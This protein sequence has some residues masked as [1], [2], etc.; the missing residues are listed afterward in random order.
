MRIVYRLS[1]FVALLGAALLTTG[2][3]P[4][5]PPGTPPGGVLR[6]PAIYKLQD[7]LLD[8]PVAPA[9]SAYTAVDGKRLHGYVEDLTAISRRYRD[10][11]HPQ[12]WGRIIGTQA[13]HDTADWM[14][15]KFKQI[16]LS[17]IHVQPF[18]LPP[19]WMPQRWDITASG[20]G[21]TLHLE[22]AQP[23]YQTP[24]TKGE[25]DLEAVY[26]GTG[27]EADF[28]GRDVKGKAVFLFSMPLPGS[29]RHTDTAEDAL[30]RAESK[31]AAAIFSVIAL[32]GNIRTQLYPTRTN[33]LTFSMGMQDGYACAI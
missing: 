6:G 33:V 16:G 29:W 1:G 4:A 31:G 8:W 17:D 3:T 24:G 19:Q 15:A 30:R 9:D 22:T 13:D 20:A 5:P 11:G 18:S 21:T 12:F 7:A 26:A 32:P 25:V 28:M 23:A 10:A 14:V 27:S 2:Q